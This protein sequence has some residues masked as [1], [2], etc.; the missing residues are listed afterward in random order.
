MPRFLPVVVFLVLALVAGGVIAW[1]GHVT[2]DMSAFLPNGAR[3][4]ERLLVKEMREGSAGRVVL[5]ALEGAAP[6]VLAA[7]N[8]ALAMRLRDSGAFTTVVNGEWSAFATPD[9]TL[10]A[11]RYL[12]A[13]DVKAERFSAEALRA[14]LELQKQNLASMASPLLRDLAASDPIGAYAD[15][16]KHWVREDVPRSHGV[17]A[18]RDGSR[19][20]L[21]ASTKAP[22]ADME[23]QARALGTLEQAFN[24]VK[25]AGVRY[26]ATGAPVFAKA[27]RQGIERDIALLSTVATAAVLILLWWIF[28]APRVVALSFVP[29]GFGILAGL[30]AVALTRGEIHGITIAFGATLIGVAVDYPIHFLSHLSDP[31]R[32]PA[33]QFAA[34]WPT[35]RLGVLTTAAAF[36]ALL[37]AGYEGLMQLGIFSV[38]GVLAAAAATR[39]LLPALVPRGFV[40][41]VRRGP[42]TGLLREVARAAPAAR[43][44]MLLLALAAAA[45]LWHSDGSVWERDIERLSPLPTTLKARDRELRAELGAPA[46]GQLLL[47]S[48]ASA[49]DTWNALDELAPRLAQLRAAG[50]VGGYESLVDFLPSPAAQRARQAQLPDSETLSA[51]IRQAARAAGFKPAA[52]RPFVA[53]VES[54]RT[55]APFALSELS[56]SPLAARFGALLFEHEGRWIA[57][58]MLKDVRDGKALA[59]LTGT[60]GA[61]EVLYLDTKQASAHLMANYRDHA[62]KL[63][64]WGGLAVVI[65]LIVGVGDW[66]R[67]LRVALAPVAVVV[68]TCAVLVLAGVKLNLFHLVSLLLVVGLG[69]DYALYFAR[70]HRGEEEWRTTFPALWRSWLTTAIGFAVLA[71]SH[72]PVLRAMG[73]TVVVGVTLC[74]V[75]G[76]TWAQARRQDAL[77]SL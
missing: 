59:Q 2:S 6:E 66:R 71:L 54:A 72:M 29:M 36:A 70:L 15:L 74:L 73:V 16:L 67:G 61:R 8:R 77:G 75:L 68:L 19:S 26:T 22:G 64:G 42:L 43:I 11:A 23:G 49:T 34:V 60:E 57:P 50:A 9:P 65:I 53:G 20:L 45:F 44:P 1:R 13:P 37:F 10:F 28:R 14:A 58:V 4:A 56:A 38:V 69:I 46:A 35:V 76:A 5:I 41:P 17:F 21:M 3:P 30:A 48:S 24:A 39:A 32:T 51:R 18:S 33:Q 47:V 40:A 63:V 62:L 12:L 27:A 52:L 31:W 7:T 25:E 55:R